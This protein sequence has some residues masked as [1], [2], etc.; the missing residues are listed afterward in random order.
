MSIELGTTDADCGLDDRKVIRWRDL[1][2]PD[3]S[4][5]SGFPDAGQ[6]EFRTTHWSMVLRAG[7]RRSPES[8]GALERLCRTYWYPLYA[9]VRRKGYSHEEAQ[10]LT[11]GFFEKFLAKDY[12][13]S[14]QRERGR[15]RTF[16]MTSLTH[17]LA[18]DW[19]RATAQKR[20]GKATL[21]SL[22]AETE[23]EERYKLEPVDYATADRLYEQRWAH[24]LMA[25]VLDRLAEEMEAARFEALKNFLL[26]DGPASYAE[27]G[28]QLGLSV[29]AV[30]SAIHRMRARFGALLR[31]E[32]SD[33]VASPEEVEEE[34]RHLIN[35]L[36]Q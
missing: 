24:A 17:F 26:G 6:R 34:I 9:F 22:D 10:D 33:T 21:I 12:L 35:L 31:D 8:E 11:Q 5:A 28:K 3:E 7:D 25:T 16:L 14:V 29:A 27:A 1:F 2:M 13:N 30:T 20:G 32:I 36:A 15:F 19:D 4:I 18:N 23:A